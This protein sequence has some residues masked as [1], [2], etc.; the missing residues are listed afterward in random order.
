MNV[1]SP[2]DGVAQLVVAVRAAATFTA[3]DESEALDNARM[4]NGA[5]RLNPGPDGELLGSD[6]PGLTLVLPPPDAAAQARQGSL[7]RAFYLGAVLLV[8]SVALSGGYFFWRDVQRDVRLSNMRS[9]FVSSVSHELK[10]PLTAI[11]MFAETLRMGRSVTRTDRDEYLD[12]I[13]NESERLTRLL[14]NVL[15]FSKIEQGRKIYRLESHSLAAVVRSAAKTMHYPLS[16]H[17]FDLRVDIND[18]LPAMT[19]DADAMEQAILNLL[20]NAMKYS[21]SGRAIDLRL[22]PILDNAVIAVTDAGCGIA[23]VE[24][25][26]IFEKFYRLPEHQMIPGTGLGLTLVEHT[27]RAHGGC[28]DVR[29]ALGEGSTFSIILPLPQQT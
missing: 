24:Q 21:G 9:Q 6:F 15:D 25:K 20:S 11:R 4:K 10:T 18:S 16:Q 5:L 19:I 29:S 17:G 27:A 3:F 13:V 14:N 28:V 1:T 7:Q 23:V 12:T 26:K 2:F 22:S 8:L